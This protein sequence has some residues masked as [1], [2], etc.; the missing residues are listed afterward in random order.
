MNNR[1]K[2]MYKHNYLIEKKKKQT[3]KQINAHLNIK[4]LSTHIIQNC[5][6]WI[7]I[8]STICK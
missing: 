6:R 7:L 8:V 3:N 5:I 4:K 2:K 1:M